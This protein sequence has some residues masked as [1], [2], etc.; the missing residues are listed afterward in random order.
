MAESRTGRSSRPSRRR[1]ALPTLADEPILERLDQAPDA[2][3]KASETPHDK[4]RREVIT[5]GGAWVVLNTR[6]AL[7]EA[8]A[9]Q[10]ARSYQRA[11][12][13]RLVES[14]Q[15]RFLARPFVRNQTWLVAVAYQSP[16][17]APLTPN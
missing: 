11:K 12:P 15:G 6:S 8:S 13:A 9:R 7:N 14:A 2:A 3:P 16:D 4:V 17:A 1:E 10:L 5:A